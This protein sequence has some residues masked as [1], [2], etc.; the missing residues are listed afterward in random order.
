[1]ILAGGGKAQPP[2]RARAHGVAGCQSGR[3][4]RPT[5]LAAAACA[6]CGFVPRHASPLTWAAGAATQRP[7]GLSPGCGSATWKLEV[8]KARESPHRP[9][10]SETSG[11]PPPWCGPGGCPPVTGRGW[12]ARG[13]S[14]HRPTPRHYQEP[15]RLI[16]S[17]LVSVCFGLFPLT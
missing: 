6:L 12:S 2:P 5:C 9:R 15:V 17:R 4:L 7:S 13:G 8:K 14:H 3:C 11:P 1:M 16:G 10:F